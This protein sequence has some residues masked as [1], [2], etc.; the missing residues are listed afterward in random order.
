MQVTLLNNGGYLEAT[1]C[2]GKVFDAVLYLHGVNLSV[3]QLRLAGF[4][5]NMVRS[6]LFFTFDE[7]KVL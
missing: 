4:T 2:V 6:T 7:V 3:S 5:D 1:P